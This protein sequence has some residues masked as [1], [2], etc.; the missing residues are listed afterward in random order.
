MGTAHQIC[1]PII[2]VREMAREEC[3]WALPTL[4]GLVR[5]FSTNYQPV[6]VAFW[7]KASDIPNRYLHIASERINDTNFD[8]AYGE[9]VRRTGQIRSPY[10]NPFRVKV[11][12][13]T[14][15]FA[16]AAADINE[17]YPGPVAT[18]FGAKTFGGVSVD[19]F[20]IYPL[21]LPLSA[22]AT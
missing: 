7:L 17:R 1:P 4:L 20:Y 9:V 21:P 10:L 5:Q 19:D 18:R 8:V 11:V 13:A 2:G 3:R 12:G 16:Q 22:V 15:P 14:D 6:T